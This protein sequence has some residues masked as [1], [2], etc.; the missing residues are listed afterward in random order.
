MPSGSQI[1]LDAQEE[2]SILCPYVDRIGVERF[3]AHTLV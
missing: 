3:W 1:K 2:L